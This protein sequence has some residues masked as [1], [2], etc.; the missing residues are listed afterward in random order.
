MRSPVIF[1]LLLVVAPASLC[2]NPTDSPNP[3]NAGKRLAAVAGT[4]LRLETGEPL[5]KAQVILESHGSD[6]LCVFYLTDEKGRFVFEDVPPGSY[7][8]QVSRNGYVDAEYGQK[9]PGGSG[10]VL[11]LAADQRMTGLVFKLARAA[12]ISGRVFD[13]D[14]EPVPKAAVSTYRASK[15]PGREVRSYDQ[16]VLTDDRGEY[17]IFN[18]AAGQYYLAVNGR[19]ED[20]MRRPAPAANQKL[21]TGYLTGYYPNTTDLAKAQ[22]ISVGPGDEIRSVDFILRPSHLVTVSGKVFNFVPVTSA[23]SGDVWLNPRGGGLAAAVQSLGSSF[24]L[25]DGSFTIRDVP[26]GE[27]DLV[28]AWSDGNP[29]EWNTARRV[30]DVGNSDID[31]VTITITRGVD[32]RG[33]LTGDGS[34]PREL[35]NLA[36]ILRPT[37]QVEVAVPPQGVKSD[38]SFQFTNVPEGTYRP[39]VF[40]LAERNL[41]LKSARYGTAPVADSGFT[42][43]PGSD[44]SLELVMSSRTAQISGQVLTGESLPA[45]GAEVVLIPDL[46]RRNERERYTSATADQYGKFSMRGLAPGDYKAFSWD[47]TKESGE[48]YAED[49]FD[50]TWLK[51]YEAK[52]VSVHLEE[53]DRKSVEL[54]LIEPARDAAPT[55]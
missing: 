53:G 55:P 3:A 20:R 31:G 36:V 29:G 16:P 37:E 34:P 46:P 24:H 50:P 9:R 25:K 19:T 13:E 28:A 54:T 22:A 47:S 43:Q 42:L 21:E 4:V 27:Y 15:K 40:G 52:G 30:L 32:V 5:K 26:P 41:Y 6:T 2:Q 33:H 44:L 7:N 39:V 12:A 23:T 35:Q 8:L 14:G 45:V 38:G 51:S 11:D 48:A 1:C 49:W 18:L 10:A 17:R